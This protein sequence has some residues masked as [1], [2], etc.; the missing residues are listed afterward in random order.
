M[1]YKL[2]YFFQEGA[3]LACIWL[4]FS[5]KNMQNNAPKFPWSRNFRLY[6]RLNQY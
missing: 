2:A 1:Y 3:F 5:T 6:L 4:I